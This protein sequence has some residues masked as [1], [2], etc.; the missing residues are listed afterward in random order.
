EIFDAYT[1]GLADSGAVDQQHLKGCPSCAQAFW[2]AAALRRQLE[3]YAQ[4]IDEQADERIEGEVL[5]RLARHRKIAASAP[6]PQLS[7]SWPKVA[8]LAAMLALAALILWRAG[9][10]LPAP[11]TPSEAGRT[12]LAAM[13]RESA[14]QEIRHYLDGSQLVLFG[15]LE[16]A[17]DCPQGD[18]VHIAQEQQLARSLLYQKHFLDPQLARPGNESL[19]KICDEL[20]LLLLDVAGSEQCVQP[21]Q[22]NLWREVLESRSTL[23]KIRLLR[24]EAVT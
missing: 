13:E 21:D 22:V 16:G 3:A 19:K 17:H 5:R 7:R 1:V 9:Q 24:R 6:L 20:E 15:V 12:F 23:V 8:A 4:S 18:A 11:S 14:R 2:E 10:P